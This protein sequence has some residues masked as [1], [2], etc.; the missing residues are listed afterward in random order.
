MQKWSPTCYGLLNYTM[1]TLYTD[2]VLFGTYFRR[3]SDGSP[4]N[5]DSVANWTA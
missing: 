3:Q 1:D 2:A 5:L 4:W